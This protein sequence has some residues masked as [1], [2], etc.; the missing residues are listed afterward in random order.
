LHVG[1]NQAL[2]RLLEFGQASTSYKSGQF[3]LGKSKLLLG[4]KKAATDRINHDNIRN[5]L[6]DW[7]K[8]ETPTL[9]V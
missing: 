8:L 3:M 6:M 9:E 7:V 2:A 4:E 1:D 5:P